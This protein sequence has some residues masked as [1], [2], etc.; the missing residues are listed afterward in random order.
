LARDQQEVAA[1]AMREEHSPG[2]MADSPI[3]LE[4]KCTQEW[5]SIVIG[6]AAV[7]AV[8]IVSA[9]IAALSLLVAG[10]ALLYAHRADVRAERADRRSREAHISANYLGYKEL[11]GTEVQPIDLTDLERGEVDWDEVDWTGVFEQEPDPARP[12]ST[13]EFRFRVTNV[14]RDGARHIRLRL[15]DSTGRYVGASAHQ[16]LSLA[17]GASDE[18]T[19][20]IAEPPGTYAYPL[21]IRMSWDRPSG[22]AGER[23]RVSAQTVPGPP[24]P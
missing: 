18:Y 5:P 14:G 2:G 6:M 21:E 8:S 4:A 9:V 20:R 1:I 24:P 13:G 17:A 23:D 11:D 15:T 16:P 10:G 22:E 7:D 12:R 19:I 3:C